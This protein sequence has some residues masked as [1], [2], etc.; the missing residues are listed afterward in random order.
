MR[1]AAEFSH[2]VI[3]CL[4]SVCVMCVSIIIIILGGG[5]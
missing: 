4:K 5:N 1:L 2:F 3:V